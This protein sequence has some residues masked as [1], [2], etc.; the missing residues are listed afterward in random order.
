MQMRGVQYFTADWSGINKR[1]G[2][3]FDRFFSSR[4]SGSRREPHRV[5]TIEFESYTIL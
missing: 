2:R 4:Y 3:D 5:D 1:V